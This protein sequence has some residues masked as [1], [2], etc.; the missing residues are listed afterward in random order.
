MK[1][2]RMRSYSPTLSRLATLIGAQPTTIQNVDIPQAF[3]TGIIDMMITLIVNRRERPR[4]G[5]MFQTIRM[6]R[7]GFLKIWSLSIRAFKRLDK[8][9]QSAL[10]EAAKHAE[11][12]GWKMAKE[13]TV[14]QTKTAEGTWHE[15]SATFT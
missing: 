3:S 13:E 10:L 14:N 11:T 1:G 8:P 2:V 5:T 6:Y 7:P 12:R 9:M 4:H 15:C